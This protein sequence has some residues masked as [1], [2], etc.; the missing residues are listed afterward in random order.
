MTKN[1][2]IMNMKQIVE[3]AAECGIPLSEYTLRRAIRDKQLPC[4]I[5]G[6]TYLISWNNVMRWLRCEDLEDSVPAGNMDTA[7]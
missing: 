6:R 1:N 3:K 5:V 7:V 4:R 2:D